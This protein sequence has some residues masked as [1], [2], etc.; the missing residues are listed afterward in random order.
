[1][2]RMK[3]PAML[4]NENVP[5]NYSLNLV[6]DEEINRKSTSIFFRIPLYKYIDSTVRDTLG[7]FSVYKNVD[8]I[9]ASCAR[10]MIVSLLIPYT[11]LELNI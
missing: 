4:N 3:P 5:I 11:T 9:K 6:E 10:E 8:C 2:N 7:R 1:M